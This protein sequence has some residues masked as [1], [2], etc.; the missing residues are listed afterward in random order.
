MLKSILDIF[1]FI[2]FIL[3]E[4]IKIMWQVITIPIIS[5]IIGAMVCILL[6]RII[7]KHLKKR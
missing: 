4:L 2:L 3:I 1:L 5:I 6:F 7:V